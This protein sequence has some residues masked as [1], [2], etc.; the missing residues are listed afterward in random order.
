M[1]LKLENVFVFFMVLFNT[2]KENSSLAANENV[3]L[4]K[5]R[6]EAP[7]KTEQ[8]GFV[9]KHCKRPTYSSKKWKDA[10]WRPELSSLLLN[11][12]K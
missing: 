10:R 4:P 11:L 12:D 2:T 6:R 1:N 5:S 8:F 7:P 9:F 3:T